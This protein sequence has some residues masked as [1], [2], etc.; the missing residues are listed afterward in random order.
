MTRAAIQKA[1]IEAP[2]LSQSIAKD[3][4]HRSPAHA[5][6]SHRL[7]G[8]KSRQPTN[9]MDHG[10]LVHELVL[11]GDKVV[12][13]DAK[14]WRTKDAKAQRDAIRL[15]GG[16]P[17]LK[18]QHEKAEVTANAVIAALAAI[19]IFLEDGECECRLEWEDDGVPCEGTP[20][21]FGLDTDERPVV[22]DL[23]VTSG[24][25][26]PGTTEKKM[27]DW[28]I[29]R[30]AYVSALN[31]RHPELAGRWRW[32]WVVVEAE[33]NEVAIYVAG[34]TL[35]QLGDMQW[36]RAVVMWKGLLELHAD[37]PDAPWPG[38]GVQTINAP[39]WAIR[40]EEDR[41]Q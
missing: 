29:Q 32:L 3:L 40:N 12:V 37:D 8:G 38:Y 25:A 21:W 28:A 23:K 14:D 27:A 17:V 11:G 1:G 36:E 34:A 24:H 30:S 15:A 13:V 6:K 31:K 4:I 18:H 33:T 2:R 41:Q 5:W 22:F 20:D 26:D 16:V 35:E 7:L 10:T 19:G 39:A 9:V